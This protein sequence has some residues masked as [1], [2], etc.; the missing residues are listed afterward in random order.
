[1]KEIHTC[2][3]RAS[4]DFC[5]KEEKYDDMLIEVLMIL[6]FSHGSSGPQHCLE[7][8]LPYPEHAGLGSQRFFSSPGVHSLMQVDIFQVTQT[9]HH[10]FLC[11][12][13]LE[14]A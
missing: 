13:L 7:F 11:F 8:R 14:T 5:W 6:M 3:S 2:P 1:M 4:L 9:L 12:S 10:G